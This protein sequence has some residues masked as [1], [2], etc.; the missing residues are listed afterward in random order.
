M[1]ILCVSHINSFSIVLQVLFYASS[2]LIVLQ[3][4]HIFFRDADVAFNIIAI[5]KKWLYKIWYTYIEI[6][7]QEKTDI[8]ITYNLKLLRAG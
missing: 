1:T 5:G 3:Y 4:Y 8:G 2:I 6:N 7:K